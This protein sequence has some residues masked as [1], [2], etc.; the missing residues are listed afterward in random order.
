MRRDLESKS[1]LHD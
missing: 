1:M